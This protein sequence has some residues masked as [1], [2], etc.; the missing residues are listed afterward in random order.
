MVGDIT[1]TVDG[2]TWSGPIPT[3]EPGKVARLSHEWSVRSGSDA[4]TVSASGVSPCEDPQ[5]FAGL[6]EIPLNDR[7][8]GAS[9]D[10]PCPAVGADGRETGHVLRLKVIPSVQWAS[11]LRLPPWRP[12]QDP[13]ADGSADGAPAE[14]P[15]RPESDQ[16]PVTEPTPDTAQR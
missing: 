15:P 11:A 6:G 13:Q 7:R 3:G 2:D 12:P 10:I 1:I 16:P 5:P 8:F 9:I 14:L 4:V